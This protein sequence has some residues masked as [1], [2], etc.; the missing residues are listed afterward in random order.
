MSGVNPGPIPSTACLEAARNSWSACTQQERHAAAC[1]TKP[2]SQSCGGIAGACEKVA[3][4]NKFHEA[5]SWG[6]AEAVKLMQLLNPLNSNPAVCRSC[7]SVHFQSSLDPL[8]L[9]FWSLVYIQVLRRLGPNPQRPQRS[10]SQLQ[11]EAI[12]VHKQRWSTIR[13][14]LRVGQTLGPRM[15]GF[16]CE[17]ENGH[18]WHLCVCVC[19]S[20]VW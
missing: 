4:Q 13:G 9:H 8:H 11:T 3:Y 7:S 10:N 2:L 5:P 19:L 1:W 18:V 17:T 15:F 12:H 6:W 20:H 16:E 14:K